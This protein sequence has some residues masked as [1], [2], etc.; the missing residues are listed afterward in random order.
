MSW[1]IIWDFCINDLIMIGIMFIV[2]KNS[3]SDLMLLDM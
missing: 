3:R 2:K 1:A